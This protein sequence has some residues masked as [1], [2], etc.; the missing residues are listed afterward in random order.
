[1]TLQEIL[2]YIEKLSHL[3]F[4][5]SDLLLDGLLSFGDGLFLHLLCLSQALLRVQVLL[6]IL[7]LS[8]PISD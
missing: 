4:S 3:V 5:I 1:M 2:N 7:Q 6:L 8:L